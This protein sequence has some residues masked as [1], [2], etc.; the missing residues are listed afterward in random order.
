[1]RSD[2]SAVSAIS[3]ALGLEAAKVDTFYAG[4]DSVVDVLGHFQAKL[5]AAKQNGVDKGKV[6]TELD[7]L[8]QQVVSIAKS[9]SF[10]AINWLNTDIADMADGS[11][12][13]SSVVSAFVRDG[14][15][16]VSVKTTQV[17]LARISLFN[18]TGSGLL[19]I[20]D[21]T[22]SDPT[23]V[24][25]PAD[26]GGLRSDTPSTDAHHGHSY[27]T[28]VN[29]AS[30][31]ATDQITFDITVDSSVYSPGQTYVGITID[32]N[33]V[34]STLGKSDGSISDGDEYARV[35]DAALKNAGVPAGSAL[36]GYANPG[37]VS[38]SVDI[39]S[40]DTLPD[41]G[42]STNITNV[43][44]TLGG[45]A[46]GLEGPLTQHINLYASASMKFTQGF[47]LDATATFSFDVTFN[48]GAPQTF[49]VT[50]SDIDAALGTT[51]G[52]VGTSSDMATLLNSIASGSGLTFG[53]SGQYVGIEVNPNVKPAQ[54]SKSNFLISNVT[55]SGV[56]GIPVSTGADGAVDFDFLDI[57]I[58]SGADIDHYI[59]GVDRMQRKVVAGASYLGSLQSRIGH[60]ADF[61]A[62]LHDLIGRGVGRL[63]DANMEE[64]SSK[65]TA[66]QAQ[67]Q[68]ALQSLTIANSS[69]QNLLA[70]FRA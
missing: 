23:P 29:P 15:G 10:Q 6:Q 17:S 34:N 33:L 16:D 59:E 40:D 70:L 25:G 2:K 21:G 48:G 66:Q 22:T 3:D 37:V 8:K 7:Q 26:L 4:M 68:L 14:N 46:F 31:S 60:Q 50:K 56:V 27:F 63:V 42:S 36:G 35:I 11:M 38:G 39:G 49:T 65:L 44:S 51:N 19:Q 67:Q 13:N 5:V 54:G 57:D 24:S 64:E 12:N 45:N 20:G 52:I 9:S 43:S 30:L 55:D 53:G 62:A 41:S 28:F 61:V 58:T 69:P 32:Q 47:K 1:M 18:S